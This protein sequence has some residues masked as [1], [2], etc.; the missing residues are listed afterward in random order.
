MD[1]VSKCG[2]RNPQIRSP[3]VSSVSLFH[4]E[5]EWAIQRMTASFRAAF[6]T[7]TK[8]G[9]RAEKDEWEEERSSSQNPV[10]PCGSG[11]AH[12]LEIL[13]LMCRLSPARTFKATRKQQQ[14]GKMREAASVSVALSLSALQVARP[15]WCRL[16]SPRF[17]NP[18]V[19]HSSAPPSKSALLLRR[20]VSEHWAIN[21]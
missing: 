20:T 18:C 8:G 1:P 6:M 14:M 4:S 16:S 5:S 10:S 15:L 11:I 12:V 7:I 13:S 9:G 21:A 17:I 2:E 19:G 3:H